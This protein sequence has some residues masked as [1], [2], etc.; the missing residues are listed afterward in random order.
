MPNLDNINRA[1][2]KGFVKYMEAN[3][4]YFKDQ[5]HMP[6]TK[7]N[8]LKG[9]DKAKKLLKNNPY[10]PDGRTQSDYCPHNNRR[11]RAHA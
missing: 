2:K 5:F 1:T 8:I 7:E 10:S 3:P 4:F 6:A 11:R 9:W